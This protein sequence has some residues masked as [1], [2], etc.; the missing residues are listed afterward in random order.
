MK[1][2]YFKATPIKYKLVTEQTTAERNKSEKKFTVPI[3]M[4]LAS[5]ERSVKRELFELAKKEKQLKFEKD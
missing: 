5:Q 3:G 4:S 2:T 1:N